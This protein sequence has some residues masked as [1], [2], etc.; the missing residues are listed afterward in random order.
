M[1]KVSIF[2][3]VFNVHVNRIPVDG[4]ITWLKYVPGV[5]LNASLDKSRK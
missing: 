3:D 2:M 4:K 1:K 5:F